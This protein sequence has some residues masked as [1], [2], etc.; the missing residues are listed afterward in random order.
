MMIFKA[1]CNEC[2]KIGQENNGWNDETMEF[3][4]IKLVCEDFYF[5][6]KQFNQK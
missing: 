4:K 1:W 3:T 5:E 6:L 2:E